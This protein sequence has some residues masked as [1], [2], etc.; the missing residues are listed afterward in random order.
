MAEKI[1]VCPVCGEDMHTYK[2]SQLYTEA[3]MRMKHKEEATTPVLDRLRAELPAQRL[4]KFNEKDYYRDVVS[5]FDPPQG[6]GQV[7]RAIN[8]DLVA[9]LVGL[10]SIYILYQI[11]LTQY[12]AFW[13]I[14]AFAVIAAAA[15]VIFRK[16][17]IGKFETEK[18][19]ESGDKDQ[20]KRAV[21]NWLKLYYCSTDNIVFGW[22]KGENIPLEQMN[23][24]LMENSKKE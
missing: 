21:G 3:L 9:I 14:V 18:S 11:Y 2:V 16:K 6:G 1:V 19:K 5:S 10:L 22:K 12:Y 24:Y 7:T 8:P 17:I 4:A 15:Y 23:Q 13:Y 20:I